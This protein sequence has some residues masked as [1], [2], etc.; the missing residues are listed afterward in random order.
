MK[1]LFILLAVLI[2]TTAS[3]GAT[4]TCKSQNIYYNDAFGN[5]GTQP[6]H[7]SETG[8]LEIKYKGELLHEEIRIAGEGQYVIAS[9]WVEFVGNREIIRAE[10]GRAYEESTYAT[11]AVLFKANQGH[12]PIELAREVVICNYSLY[13]YP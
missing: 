9:H 7:G 13:L 4:T 8:R 11:T 6:P 5:Y 10:N 2:T 12:A 3:Y 1:N